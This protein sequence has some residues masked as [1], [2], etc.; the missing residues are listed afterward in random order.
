MDQVYH[1][2]ECNVNFPDKDIAMEH[3]N[4]TGHVLSVFNRELVSNAS[5]NRAIQVRAA[6]LA[7]GSF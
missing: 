7:L 4:G 6:F 2:N 3:R 1:C 5:Q